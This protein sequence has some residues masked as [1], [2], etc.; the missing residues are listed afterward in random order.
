MD[1]NLV[2][3]LHH[4]VREWRRLAE[5][6]GDA[7]RTGNWAL[8]Q[9]CQREQAQLRSAIERLDNE[10]QAER[11]PQTTQELRSWVREEFAGLIEVEKQN[12]AWVELH[13]EKLTERVLAAEKSRG[14]LRKLRLSYSS[15][16]PNSCL[17]PPAPSSTYLA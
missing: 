5:A 4:L 7:I 8:A 17:S 11:R 6:E 1:Q 12:L 15:A 13:R 14:N 16:D 2:A 9:D 3:R 10:V